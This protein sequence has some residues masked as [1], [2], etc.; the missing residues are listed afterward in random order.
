MFQ[1]PFEHREYPLFADDARPLLVY[2]GQIGDEPDWAFESHKHDHFTEI[3]YICDGEGDFR[4]NDRPYRARKGDLLIYHPG[5]LHEERS[6]PARPLRTYFCA[7]SGLRLAGAKPGWLLSEQAEPV[8]RAESC[9][10]QI[11]QCFS[12]LLNELRSQTWGHEMICQ[13]M[14]NCILILILRIADGQGSESVG[15]S[16]HTIGA[17][18]KAFIDLNYTRDLPLSE[19]AS[20]LY[21]SPHYLSHAF[22]EETG[23]SPINYLIQRRIGEAKTLLLTTTLTVQEIAGRIGYENANYFSMAFKRGTGLTPSEFRKK[24]KK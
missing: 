7:V 3:I 8:I 5:V 10:P 2:A 14:L 9:G 23:N 17:K 18:A 11:E 12:V 19:S 20:R 21:L 13:H 16:S 24:T 22:K 6:D 15:G 4:I 1:I